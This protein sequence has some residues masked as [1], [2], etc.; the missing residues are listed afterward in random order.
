MTGAAKRAIDTA[1]LAFDIEGMHRALLHRPVDALGWM[2][3][4]CNKLAKLSDKR[5][6]SSFRCTSQID[7]SNTD[8]HTRSHYLPI[9]HDSARAFIDHVLVHVPAGF[10]DAAIYALE[11]VQRLEQKGAQPIMIVLVDLGHKSQFEQRVPHF[12]TSEVWRGTTPFVP[13]LPITSHEPEMLETCI[14]QELKKR[15]LPEPV[16]IEGEIRPGKFAPI[17]V[18]LQEPSTR[19]KVT[20]ESDRGMI[21]TASYMIRLRFGAPVTGPIILGFG[22]QYGMGQFVPG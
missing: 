11:R 12:G 6:G 2:Q 4:L 13:T 5:G 15:R 16:S 14:R 20:H 22:S 19:V 9:S 7:D 21:S 17:A 3:A 18:A 8:W 10:D 1:L